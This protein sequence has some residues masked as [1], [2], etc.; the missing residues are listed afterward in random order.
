MKPWRPEGS[1]RVIAYF[2]MEYG[3]DQSL[4]MYSGGLGVLSG[5]HL[6]TASDLGIPLVGIGLL[7]RQ[8]FFRQYL[9]A[10]GYQQESYPENDWYNMPVH[11]CLDSNGKPLRI[12]VKVDGMDIIIA[13]WRIDVG[14]VNLYLLDTNLPENGDDI[15]NITATLYSGDNNLRIR[16][17]ILLGVGGVQALKALAIE[18][19]VFHMNEG[20]SAFLA[21]ERIRILMTGHGLSFDEARQVVWA[22]NV[23][24]TH[25]PV[26]AGNE[27]FEEELIK[28]YLSSYVE[29]MGLTWDRFMAFGRENPD[30][31]DEQFCMTVFALRFA[32]HCN[33][34]SALHGDITRD[35]WKA[36]WP[37]VPIQEIPIRHITNGVH[38][39]T[40]I[41]HDLR[42]LLDR[43]FGPRFQEE[44]HDIEMW[45]RIS[46]I[47]DEELWR[48]HERRRERMVAYIR[49]RVAHQMRRRGVPASQ[50]DWSRDVLSPYALTVSFARRFA[51]YKRGNLLLRD[52]DRLIKLLS[53]NERPLQLVFAGKAH[54]TIILV[55]N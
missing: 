52:P 54:P 53:D 12:T 10:D 32:A 38:T 29:K 41:A 25:T 15:R 51:T 31:T 18:P 36:L 35:M 14:R 3:L 2:S 40:W 20:H 5:D 28:R 42:N 22:T 44:P 30:N 49:D 55:K 16:Q 6:K 23:F 46:R 48:T 27:R 50:L 4:P 43:Y 21:L 37:G 24:T 34:V 45:D 33:A 17:E 11:R 7:Y 47:S 9:N 8:G 13:I 39:R 26:P 1:S 19:A